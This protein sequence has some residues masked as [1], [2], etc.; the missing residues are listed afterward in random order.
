M[1]LLKIP[2]QEEL[3]V[4]TV[5]VFLA[6]KFGILTMRDLEELYGDAIINIR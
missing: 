5:E 1:Q 2:L 4:D 3:F 6:G